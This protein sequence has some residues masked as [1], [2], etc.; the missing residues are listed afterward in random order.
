[1]IWRSAIVLSVALSLAA[2]GNETNPFDT[3]EATDTTTDEDTTTDDGLDQ[4]NG[5]NVTLP[6]TANPTPDTGLYRYEEMTEDGD[7][8][9]LRPMYSASSDTFSFDNLAFDGA[10]LFNRDDV[11]PS[12][13]PA[14]GSGPFAVY[15]N[16]ETV[17][18]P[19]NGKDIDQLPYKAIYA[20]STSGD[21]EVVV[22]RTGGFIPYGFGGFI[23]QRNDGASVVIPQ[24]GQARFEGAYAGLRD[25]D[26]QGGLEYTVANITVDVDF[27][28]FNGDNAQDA[29]RG[30][31]YDR[32][33]YDTN[34]TE[35]TQDILDALTAQNG[36]TYNSLPVLLMDIGP[37]TV[38]VNGEASGTLQSTIVTTSGTE[39]LESGSYYAV[40]SGA[41]PDEIT[42][43][44]VIESSDPRVDGI[45]V[46]ET[47]AFIAER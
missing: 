47:G 26:G 11:V 16:P 36:V 4:I 41:A 39:V 9:A 25:F 19:V 18:D 45:T 3:T 37:N 28:D 42:G 2:C 46:R 40:L 35:V 21:T 22:V 43:V 7:G 33:V 17:T 6:G 44:V 30:R 13:G 8:F 38:D 27:E 32:H 23:Y 15:E 29:I 34:G 24:T 1:M 12:L 5:D 20:A 14:G 31:I 10:N